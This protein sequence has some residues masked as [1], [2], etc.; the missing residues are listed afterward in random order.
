MPDLNWDKYLADF[1][2]QAKDAQMTDWGIERSIAYAHRLYS[3]DLPIIY[4]PKHLSSLL[5]YDLEYLLGVSNA[6]QVFYR[7]FSIPKRTKG[8]RRISE[9]LPGLKD[10]QYWLANN[11]FSCFPV[12]KYAKAYLKKSSIKAN[13]RFH[14]RQPCV[15]RLDIKN[16][17][18]SINTNKIFR[19]L[20]AHGYTTS[21]SMLIAKLCTLYNELPQGAPT[22]PVLSNL[23]MYKADNRLGAFAQYNGYRYT[24]YADD[25]F[26]SGRINIGNVVQFTKNVLMYEGFNLNEEKTRVYRKGQQQRVTGIVVNEKLQATRK[27]RRQLRQDIHYIERNGLMGHMLKKNITQN[28]YPEHLAGKAHFILQINPNDKDA[29]H[30]L[31]VLEPI[32]KRT[33]G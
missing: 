29:K 11:F 5:G 19:Q 4:S 10:I 9:P 12:S 13:A 22:S 27:Y 18:P 16:F 21:V 17:F 1:T 2:N 31:K 23:L 20:L 32:L 28:N 15:M 26:F 6:P 30:A 33:T 3:Q 25:L 24:R 7:S 8:K 14:R